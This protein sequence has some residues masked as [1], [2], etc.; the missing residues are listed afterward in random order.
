MRV[1]LK[2]KYD[3]LN[4]GRICFESPPIVD[5]KRSSLLLLQCR[6]LSFQYRI[7]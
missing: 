5:V 1:A 6:W 3:R 4:E 7:S 2:L